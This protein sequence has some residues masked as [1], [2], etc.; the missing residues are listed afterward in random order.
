MLFISQ[1]WWIRH[2]VND[3]RIQIDASGFT[4]DTLPLKAITLEELDSSKNKH[5][6]FYYLSVYFAIGI[7][8]AL[9]GGIKTMMTFLSGMRASR[10]IFNNL[11][12]LVLH[13]KIRF[14]DVTPVGRIM[15]RLSK[16]IEGID[17]ELIPYLEVTIFCLIQCASI[18]ILITVITPRFLIVAVI[19]FVLYYFVGNWY[20]TAS[21]EL[22]RIDSITK[23]PIF[24]HFS[25]TLVGVCTIRAFG[26]ERLSL[27]HI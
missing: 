7:I 2:W 21:R 9:L 17:Q 15:N 16:D 14:F 3:A 25:E 6:A 19:V 10:K 12:D 4:T 8:Q 1:S 11:L 13:A 22:K 24:Q 20:L 27:I 5:T 18:I 23:S 26:D